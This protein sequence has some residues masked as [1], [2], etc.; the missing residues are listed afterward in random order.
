ML[1]GFLS[2]SFLLEESVG[3]LQVYIGVCS[4]CASCGGQ[5]RIHTDGP[6]NQTKDMSELVSAQL[7]KR[8]LEDVLL[9]QHEF[10]QYVY[11]VLLDQQF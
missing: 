5:T 7:L 1:L 10:V 2:A 8:C 11:R 6:C 3:S 4:L 9:V